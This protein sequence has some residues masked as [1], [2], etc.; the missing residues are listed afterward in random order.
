MEAG[1]LIA[2]GCRT[3]KSQVFEELKFFGKDIPAQV[4]I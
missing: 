3:K 2:I 1:L 4:R